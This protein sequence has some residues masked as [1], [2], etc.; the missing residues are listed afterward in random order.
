MPQTGSMWVSMALLSFDVLQALSLF[1]RLLPRKG[2]IMTPVAHIPAIGHA[3]CDRLFQTE[4]DQGLRGN[5]QAPAAGQQLGSSSRSRTGPSADCGASASAGNRADDGPEYGA[6]ADELAGPPV[7]ADGISLSA[8]H[9][10]VRRF[11]GIPLS[12]HGD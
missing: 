2:V 3:H 1:I 6:P 12:V 11:E 10:T 7:T 4:C 8:T 9:V 5:P